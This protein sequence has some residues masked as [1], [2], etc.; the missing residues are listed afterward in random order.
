MTDEELRGEF[1]KIN[2]RFDAVEKRFDAMEERV[3]TLVSSVAADLDQRID[4]LKAEQRQEFATVRNRLDRV[5]T[6]LTGLEMQIAGVNRAYDSH[7]QELG[8]LRGNQLAYKDA[9]DALVKR[10]FPPPG[11]PPIQQ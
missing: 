4:A 10:L 8:M 1:A 5:D 9:L 7:E 11:S 3:K 6:R 2:G